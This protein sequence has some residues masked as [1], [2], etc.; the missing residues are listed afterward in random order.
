MPENLWTEALEVASE[1]GPHQAAQVLGLCYSTVKRRLEAQGPLPADS[2]EASAVPAF[3]ELL[4]PMKGGQVAGCIL[5]V[6]TPSGN[7][8]RLE[9]KEVSA[10][11]LL[12]VLRGLVA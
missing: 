5:E 11:D 9:I 10:P 3:I 1:W 12:T 8:L 7:H 2:P 4:N 6:Q